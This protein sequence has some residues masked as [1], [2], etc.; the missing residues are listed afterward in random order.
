M[1]E[2]PQGEAIQDARLGNGKMFVLASSAGESVTT[3]GAALFEAMTSV[4]AANGGWLVDGMVAASKVKGFTKLME[5][6]H[7]VPW[8]EVCPS[9]VGSGEIKR[10]VQLARRTPLTMLSVLGYPC[11]AL[12]GHVYSI[13]LFNPG[14]ELMLPYEDPAHRLWAV[15]VHPPNIVLPNQVFADVLVV[16]ANAVRAEYGFGGQWLAQAVYAY[17]FAEWSDN[18][19]L[20]PLDPAVKLTDMSY[21]HMLLRTADVPPEAL[22]GLRGDEFL[23]R[24]AGRPEMMNP[25]ELVGEQQEYVLLRLGP[26]YPDASDA[27]AGRAAE[28]LGRPYVKRLILRE[29][30]F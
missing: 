22:A 26:L 10:S 15:H 11:W 17:R 6:R 13:D 5:R 18:N 14:N 25:C 19:Y 29:Q 24:R 4:V 2:R 30:P 3:Q 8:E 20:R 7:E 28:L 16:A 23:V 1:E 12:A 9:A 21:A 27:I